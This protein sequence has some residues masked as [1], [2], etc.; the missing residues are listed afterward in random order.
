MFQGICSGA[1]PGQE[2]IHCELAPTLLPASPSDPPLPSAPVAAG[3]LAD[4]SL[5]EPVRHSHVAQEVG[6]DQVF[7]SVSLFLLDLPPVT[8]SDPCMIHPFSWCELLVWGGQPLSGLVPRR[9]HRLQAEVERRRGP[10]VVQ[11]HWLRAFTTSLQRSCGKYNPY[12]KSKVESA[13]WD[14]GLTHQKASA[15][16][17]DLSTY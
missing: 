8:M 13:T 5:E 16:D 9:L 17:H 7:S 14:R 11:Q 4:L 10:A 12:L 3:D 2:K 1:S 6:E 15:W